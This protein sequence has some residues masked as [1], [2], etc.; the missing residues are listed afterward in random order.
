MIVVIIITGFIVA[1]GTAIIVVSIGICRWYSIRCRSST[2]R[3]RSNCGGNTGGSTAG[4]SRITVIVIY[5]PHS[6]R[7]LLLVV[8]LRGNFV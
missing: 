5:Y 8:L 4:R 2:T 7:Y 3:S 6:N 1:T